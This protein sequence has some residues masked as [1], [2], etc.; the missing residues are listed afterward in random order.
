MGFSQ[1]HIDAK[2]S[3]KNGDS[4]RLTGL[5]GEPNRAS[6]RRTWDLIC[7]LARDS[8]LPWCVIGDVNNVVDVR[9]KVGGSQY[10]SRLIEGCN[11]VIHD[12]VDRADKNITSKRNILASGI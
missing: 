5:Y 3:M 7:N 1:N 11:E 9:E 4:W 2:I 6:R 12:V 8:N 10:P